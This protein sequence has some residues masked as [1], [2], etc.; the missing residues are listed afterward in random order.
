MYTVARFVLATGERPRYL[1]IPGDK[2]FCI[3]RYGLRP[4]SLLPRAANHSS[5]VALCT[6]G[7][8]RDSSVY[9]ALSA[10][11]PWCWSLPCSVDKQNEN[12]KGVI[13]NVHVFCPVGFI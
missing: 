9:T 1:G 11:L 3:T 8:I 5:G 7:P 2:E 13:L 12:D 6:C 10:T 4:P